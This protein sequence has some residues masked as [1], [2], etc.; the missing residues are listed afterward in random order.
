MDSI[1]KRTFIVLL[2]IWGLFTVASA[3]TGKVP[4][5]EGYVEFMGGKTW[6]KIV[7]SGDSIPLIALHGGPGVPHYYLKPLEELADE[8]PV[9]FYDQRGCGNSEPLDPT[10]WTV[11]FFVEE[12]HQIREQLGLDYVHILGHSWGGALAT[13]YVLTHPE[14]VESVILA[15]PLISTPL[16][17]K[18]QKTYLK[19]LPP[20]MQKDVE[21]YEDAL[22]AGNE[23]LI[24]KYQEDFNNAMDEYYQRHV[25]RLDPWPEVL[26]ISFEKM[27]AELYGAMWGPSE[28]ISNGSLQYYDRTGDL[29]LI[30]APVLFTCGRF[31]EASPD[32]MAYFHTL[33]P[34]SELEV[35]IRSAHSSML[36]QPLRYIPKIRE[37]LTK[38]E[39]SK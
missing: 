12:L 31:D 19:D 13:D 11:E 35:F 6:Y 7:G 24:L 20:R 2:T 22:L 36:E 15:S 18:D 9:I 4:D 23:Y 3:E 39:H 21:K 33:V 28:F 17:I 26:N 25:C 14:G 30:T 38:V 1:I 8:R 29:H 34:G 32:T 37:F 27:N 5:Q 10:Y 16:W